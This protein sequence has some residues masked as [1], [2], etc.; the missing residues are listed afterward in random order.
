MADSYLANLDKIDAGKSARNRTTLMA[1]GVLAI[2]NSAYASLSEPDN[3]P[4]DLI[5]ASAAEEADQASPVHG[6][7][8][9]TP[10]EL[11]AV[12]SVPLSFMQK[13]EGTST[14]AAMFCKLVSDRGVAKGCEPND[15]LVYATYLKNLGWNPENQDSALAKVF[16]KFRQTSDV[17]SQASMTSLEDAKQQYESYLQ[18]GEIYSGCLSASDAEIKEI[19]RANGVPLDMLKQAQTRGDVCRLLDGYLKSNNAINKDSNQFW[20]EGGA[21]PVIQ[22]RTGPSQQPFV[23]KYHKTFARTTKNDIVSELM[24]ANATTPV[25]VILQRLKKEKAAQSA[26]DTSKK[27]YYNHYRIPGENNSSSMGPRRRYSRNS[28]SR[29]G[30]R[31]FSRKQ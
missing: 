4:A 28:R 9:L 17:F 12:K 6:V 7:Q 8:L 2:T 31:R 18:Q 14:G 27:G 19:I 22:S 29:S 3:E 30:R 16:R 20:T 13:T 11:E 15:P 23:R 21:I 25:A 24:K 26:D 1:L 5:V 10:I